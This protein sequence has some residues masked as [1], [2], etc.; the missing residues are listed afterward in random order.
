MG[1]TCSRCLIVFLYE[2]FVILLI[3]FGCFWRIHLSKTCE[4]KQL[5]GWEFFVVQLGT[6]YHHQDSEQVI[7]P[8]EIAPL[9]VWLVR[10]RRTNN[11]LF[12][13][14]SKSERFNQPLTKS[15]F[16]YQHPQPLYHVMQEEI[17]YLDFVQGVNFEFKNSLK[18]HGTKYLLIFDISCEEICSSKAFVYIVTAGRHRGLN[19]IFIKHKLFHQSRL[20]R[21]VELQNTHIVLL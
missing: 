6:A 10:P 4:T 12:R 14:G 21:D 8:Q 13:N 17:D 15:T 16:F 3:I 18:N 9:Y 5:F 2:L 1:Q 11:K 7:F 19:T 20:G